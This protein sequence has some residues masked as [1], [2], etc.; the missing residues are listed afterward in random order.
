M[1][2]NHR[3]IENKYNTRT[4]IINFKTAIF[5]PDARTKPPIL[6]KIS[7]AEFQQIRNAKVSYA[8]SPSGPIKQLTSMKSNA[9]SI[10]EFIGSNKGNDSQQPYFE[11]CKGMLFLM[12]SQQNYT[13]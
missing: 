13:N 12:T 8:I 3:S 9:T 6:V 11:F 7:H 1:Y 10:K 5:I 2:I 4:D